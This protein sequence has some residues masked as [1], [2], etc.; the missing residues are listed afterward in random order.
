MV[1]IMLKTNSQ[2][3][4]YMFGS[5]PTPFYWVQ[6][7]VPGREML[8]LEPVGANLITSSGYSGATSNYEP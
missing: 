7:G 1:H 8:G 4:E 3:N 2:R 5:Y 6:S